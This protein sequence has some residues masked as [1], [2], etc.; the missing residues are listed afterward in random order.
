MAIAGPGRGTRRADLMKAY[1]T[2]GVLTREIGTKIK[3]LIQKRFFRA[4]F[5]C[6]MIPGLRR[7]FSF[8]AFRQD[9]CNS[10]DTGKT[11]IWGS[12]MTNN[13]DQTMYVAIAIGATL[14]IIWVMRMA[15]I[16]F[17]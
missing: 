8:D 14:V 7:A 5:R 12:A 16:A 13:D 15:I 9:W 3:A 11:T 10:V 4:E 1:L 2:S 6:K 17:S